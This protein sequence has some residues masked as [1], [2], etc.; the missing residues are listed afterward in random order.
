MPEEIGY[1]RQVGPRAAAPMPLSSPE[2]FGAGIGRAIGALGQ[3]AHRASIENY[4]LERR[5]T[6]NEEWARFQHGFALHRENMDGIAREARK[7]GSTG[8]AMRMGEAWQAG[9]AALLDSITE[10]EVRQRAAA[11][12][13]E[14]GLRF[15]TTE[16][17]F[18]EVQ[19]IDRTLTDW[20][21]ASNVSRNRIRR[22]ENPKDFPA[23]LQLGREAI[24]GLG[25][26]AE[27]ERKALAE[28]DEGAHVS[29]FQ[30]VID[31]DPRLALA[32]LDSELADTIDPNKLE[33]LR[34]A[35][36]VEIRRAEAAAEHQANLE[37]AALKREIGVAKELASQGID[38]ADQLPALIT[39]AAALGETKLALDLEGIAADSGFAKIYQDAP[40]VQRERRMAALEAIEKRSPNED[41]ELKWL[42]DNQAGLDQRFNRDPAGFFARNGGAAAPPALDLAD[43]GSVSARAEWARNQ[44]EA[45]GRP[46]PPLTANEA[47]SLK[48]NWDT[49]KRADQLQVMDALAQF[50]ADQAAAAARLVDSDPRLAVMVTLPRQYRHLALDGRDV[51]K[52]NRALL[53]PATADDEAAFEDQINRFDQALRAIAPAERQAVLAISGRIAAGLL[54]QNGGEINGRLHWQALNMALGATGGMGTDKQRGGIARWGEG[55]FLLPDGMRAP[56]FT[57]AVRAA[58]QGRIKPVNPDG[59]PATLSRAQPVAIGRGLYE[60]RAPSGDPLFGSDGKPWRVR[61][62]GGQ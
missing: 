17:E 48:A 47:S 60:F 52:A 26:P 50:P 35:A 2:D 32:M 28:W 24:A 22:L 9:R 13:E 6:A 49:G 38:V 11:T 4:Q 5:A 42:K 46:V 19:R 44:S 62:G 36:G 45:T 40:P 10:D 57:A 3:Q 33:I 58:A 34:N 20:T 30:G 18:E 53:K 41:R 29:F 21:E 59:S 15:R 55:W 1:S 61:I 31:R 14:S 25:L 54:D 23:E 51:L 39:R 37:L 7:D 27:Q 16:A 8:H 43:P 56:E 12:F